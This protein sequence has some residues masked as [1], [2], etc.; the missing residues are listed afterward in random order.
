MKTSLTNRERSI[1][2]VCGLL[3]NEHRLRILLAIT[4]FG[5]VDMNALREILMI[6]DVTIRHHLQK[7]RDFGLVASER[8]GRSLVFSSTRSGL[9]SMF[10]DLADLLEG[11]YKT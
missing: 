3:S 9:G 5:E 4:E 10:R 1:A 6:D 8:S 7:L 11:P 2:R